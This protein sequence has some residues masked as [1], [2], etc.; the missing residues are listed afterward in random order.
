MKVVEEKHHLL[1]TSALM[2]NITQILKEKSKEFNSSESLEILI[3]LPIELESEGLRLSFTFDS[4]AKGINPNNFLKKKNHKISL[5]PDYIL[6]FDRILQTADVQNKELF[7]A[8]IEDTLD[9]DLDE[10]MPGSELSLYNKR[11]AQGKIENYKKFKMLIDQYIIL[12]EDANIYKIPWKDILSF[13]SS[14]TDF[15]YI[16]PKLLEYILPYLDKETLLSLTTKRKKLI[17]NWKALPI[18]KEYKK[19]LKKYDIVFYAPIVKGK[20]QFQ[21][22]EKKGKAIFVYDIK[23]K[24]VLELEYRID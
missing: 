3:T 20:F 1:Q 24:K 7:L 2:N 22:E 18:A 14:K 4:T 17:K 21:E 23:N 19:E 15:N 9:K 6:L 10:R 16:S 5:N 13:H 8:L 11:F 12:T